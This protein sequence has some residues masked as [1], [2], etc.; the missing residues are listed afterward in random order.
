MQRFT[1]PSCGL[2][3]EPEFHY[4]SEP[5]PRPSSKVSDSQ[6]GQYLYFENNEKGAHREL[7]RHLCGTL[8]LVE[9]D[10]R[11]HRVIASRGVTEGGA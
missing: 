3:D 2:R 5:K 4:I 6:W 11:T 7:Y 9:R 1:C 8:T 10:T